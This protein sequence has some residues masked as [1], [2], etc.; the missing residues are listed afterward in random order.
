[1]RTP[2]GVGSKKDKTKI[3]DLINKFNKNKAFNNN[4]DTYTHIYIY[5]YIYIY[6]KL[7]ILSRIIK[8]II[9]SVFLLI[10]DV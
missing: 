5:I 3:K 6:N 4:N 7:F 2:T 10:I 8:F 1:M 9:H